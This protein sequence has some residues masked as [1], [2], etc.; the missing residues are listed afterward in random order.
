MMFRSSVPN[1]EQ[2]AAA[3]QTHG[4][5]EGAILSLPET[6]RTVLMLR[7]IEELSTAETAQAL[8]LTEENV[9]VRLHRARALLRR[10]LYARAGT[11]RPAAFSFMAPRCDRVV[12]SVLERLSTLRGPAFHA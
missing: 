2:E 11:S 9:K 5:L 7:D 6:Y 1:P 10:E 3:A 4:M 8:E 12:K